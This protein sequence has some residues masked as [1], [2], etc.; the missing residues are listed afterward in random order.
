MPRV[1][2]LSLF[3]LVFLAAISGCGVNGAQSMEVQAL[4]ARPSPQGARNAAFYMTVVNRTGQDDALVQVRTDACGTVE[5]HQ[6]ALDDQSVMRMAPV[7]QG[8]I[9]VPAGN[10]ITLEPGGLHVMCLDVLEPLTLGQ[11]IP[12]TVVFEEAGEMGVVAEVRTEAP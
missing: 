7:P 4:W 12:V 10:T 9:P 11:Q 5:L 6:S 3:Y 1:T 8:R 2:F